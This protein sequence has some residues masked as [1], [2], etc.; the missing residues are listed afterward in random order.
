MTTEGSAEVP[1]GEVD[2]EI[3]WV[4][5][6]FSLNTRDESARI[7]GERLA[8]AAAER[9]R[10]EARLAEV[11]DS[12]DGFACDLDHAEER[13]TALRAAVRPLVEA[14]GS[15]RHYMR[16]GEGDPFQLV[17]T[18]DAIMADP[19]IAALLEGGD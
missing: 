16:Y 12:R 10:L 11:E 5:G 4:E 2:R 1:A 17:A 9:T 18:I 15:A 8:S 19:A 3:V 13:L 14:A 7:I 6:V